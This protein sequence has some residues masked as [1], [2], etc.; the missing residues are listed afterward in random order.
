MDQ[1][2]RVRYLLHCLVWRSASR[3]ENQIDLEVIFL[4]EGFC[5]SG[6]K[7][8]VQFSQA[9]LTLIHVVQLMWLMDTIK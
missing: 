5:I 9:A 7:A 3:I 2:D 8:Q 1:W 6:C 4:F